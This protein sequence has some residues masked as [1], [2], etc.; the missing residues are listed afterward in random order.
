MLSE[1]GLDRKTTI[2]GL[3]EYLLK[4]LHIAT[5]GH[6]PRRRRKRRTWT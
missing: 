3:I 1:L 4:Q 2:S 6:Q 5:G